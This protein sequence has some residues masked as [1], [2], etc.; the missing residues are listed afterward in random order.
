MLI[1]HKN[2]FVGQD[3]ILTYSVPFVDGMVPARRESMCVAA[4]RA[5]AQALNKASA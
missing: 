1:V 3:A 5:R 2:S 4:S